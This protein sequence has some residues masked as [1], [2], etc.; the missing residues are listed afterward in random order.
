MVEANADLWFRANIK[1]AV[2]VTGIVEHSFRS[3][4]F[5]SFFQTGHTTNKHNED[6][7]A[8]VYTE[9]LS[10]RRTIAINTSQ[11]KTEACNTCAQHFQSLLYEIVL[12]IDETSN[13][14]KSTKLHSIEIDSVFVNK[15]ENCTG[16]GG[17]SGF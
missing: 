4:M 13:V 5:H 1:S 6:I 8:E 7:R 16:I 9:A 14:M 10:S 2:M 11:S 12:T 15:L 17:I 3:F